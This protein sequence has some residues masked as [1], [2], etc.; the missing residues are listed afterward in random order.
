[1]ATPLSGTSVTINDTAPTTDRYNLSVCRNSSR[2]WPADLEHL[3]HGQPGCLPATRRCSVIDGALVMTNADSNGNY[4]FPDM[5]NGTYTI[6]PT[7]PG[8]TFTPASRTVTVNGGN[9]TGID[10]T[11]D[12]VPTSWS[13][14]GAISPGAAG[15]YALVTVA[16]GGP[17][18]LRSADASGNFTF[19]GLSNGTY[20]VTPS[21]P[22]YVFSPA[23]RS[24]TISGADVIGVNFTAQTS[25]RRG[26]CPGRSALPPAAA[27][28]WSRLP[29]D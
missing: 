14:S 27:V 20:T 9:V 11:A 23:S 5:P 24:V 29:G 19:S 6:A 26:A 13:M 3:R 22:G 4:S 16:G 17:P 2:A 10:F 21:K 7:K 28:L 1:M 25:P 12:G 15:S 18:V 8:Y